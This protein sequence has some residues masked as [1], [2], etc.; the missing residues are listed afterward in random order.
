MN[1]NQYFSRNNDELASD[2]KIINANVNGINLKFK[3]D[4]G[5]FSRDFLDY[6]SKL[7]LEKMTFDVEEKQAILD[8]G[9]G[10]GPIG[11]YAAKISKNP[12]VML[13]INPR[14]LSLSKENLVLN[15]VSAEVVESDCLDAVL[16][17]KFGLI[18]CNPPIHAGKSVVY[19]IF[20]QAY[21]VLN[22]LGSFWIVIQQK[23]G[24]PSAIK[25]L[26][27]VFDVVEIIYKKKGFYIIKSSKK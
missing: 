25:K 6:A 5:V 3:T 1:N 21:E 27:E 2:P 23:H 4:I 17:E 18:I 14:A 13:D 24:A 15:N 20:E 9:C 10:Y 22:P 7:L 26:E 16:N 8:V 19:K 11:I 12:V